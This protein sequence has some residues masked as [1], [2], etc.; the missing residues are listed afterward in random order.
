MS[1]CVLEV[2]RATFE[3]WEGNSL[4]TLLAVCAGLV[5]YPMVLAAMGGIRP[6]DVRR[7]PVI[8][9]RMATFMKNPGVI[10]FGYTLKFPAFYGGNG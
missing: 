1:V 3:Q 2:Y 10:S 8:G 6:E 4:A 9:E 5:V 7:L